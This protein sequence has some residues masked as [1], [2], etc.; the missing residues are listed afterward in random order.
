MKKTRILA[1]LA[2]MTIGLAVF[3][4]KA[5][6][7]TE[8][9][10]KV[11]A[12]AVT[13]TAEDAGEAGVNVAMSTAT[14]GAVI[15]YTIDES[16][17]SLKYSEPLTFSKDTEIKAFAVKEGIENSPISVAK[18]SIKTKTIT[19]KVYVCAKCQKEY[20]TAQEAIDCC[21]ET[22]DTTAPA[23]VTE[24]VA[25]AKDSS[26]VLTWKDATDE[27][28]FGYLVSWKAESTGRAL[29]ALEKDSLIAAKGQH[30]CVVTGLTNGTKYTFTVKT[31]DTSG[32]TSGG[33]TVKAAPKAGETL[34]ISLSVP[35]AKSNTSVTV[36]VNVETAAE[37][38][39]DVVYKK[40]GSVNA[41]TLLADSDAKKA[42]QNSAGNK[43][44]TF[45]IT[46]AD[47]TANG[48][49]TVA[50]L[51]SDGREEAAQI[52]IDNFDFTPP[53]KVK[54]VTATYSSELK[55]IILNWKKPVDS[56]FDHVEIVYT[57]N[58]GKVDSVKSDV[59]AESSVNKTFSDIDGTKAYYTYYIASVD[60]L[61]N[62]S[63]EVKY[64]VSVNKTVSNVPEGFVEIPSASIAG[65]ESWTP[66][67][68]VFVSGRKLEIASFYMSAHPVTRGEY[69]TLMGKDPS[70]AS[71]YDKDGNK[72]TGDDAVKNNPVNYISWYD[73]L[74]YCNTRS[75]NEGL[76]PCYEI[77][78]KT[79][80]KDWGSVPTNNN[81]TWNA[82]TCDFT[83]DGY[84]LPTEAE[85]EWAARGGENYTYAGSDDID[86]VAWYYEN[87]NNTGTR[88]VKTKKA[89][90]YGLYDMSGNVWEWCWDWYGSISRKTPG[91]GPA[92]GSDRCL[93]GGSWIYY[94]DY[95]QVAFRSRCSP[96]DRY[97]YYGFRLVRNAN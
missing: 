68:S 84:R 20:K 69:K 11:Y 5:E 83:A 82:A 55:V 28:I 60:K 12:E 15:Y 18:V 52:T 64:N 39:V 50:A 94:A 76:T 42:E 53:A 57:T 44:W 97:G 19:E 89:N 75:I 67:S 48:T 90:A 22:L 8:Y 2:A 91:T 3:G 70:Y 71:A 47:E 49:Y 34:K 25:A 35:E 14:E 6:T 56:D 77:D 54:G 79:D 62:K 80:P 7:E 16:S 33:V 88:D 27:D 87:T 63:N 38:I 24:P 31:M 23:D 30:G 59:I 10:D 96:I 32:N 17:E 95:A 43:Q 4:C 81:S 41:A 92:S 9:V 58:D 13:F 37:K 85:W 45:E 26:V 86:E 78:G 21:A 51:D 40:D 46:A 61:G 93:R 36:T 29:V 1:V 73:A 74:V 65:T 72:L 66:S